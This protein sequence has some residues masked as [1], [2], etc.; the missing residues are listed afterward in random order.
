L[1]DEKARWG[2]G[3]ATSEVEGDDGSVLGM[4][5]CG[6]CDS[7]INFKDEGKILG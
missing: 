4:L 7:D 5:V 2:E 6:R 3:W 1:Y